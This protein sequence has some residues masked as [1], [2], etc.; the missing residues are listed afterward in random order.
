[1][2]AP[3]CMHPKEA[4]GGPSAAAAVGRHSDLA[5][6]T[7]QSFALD[8]KQ[9]STSGFDEDTHLAAAAVGHEL[10]LS[11]GRSEELEL[12]TRAFQASQ[13]SQPALVVHPRSTTQILTSSLIYRSYSY[14]VT[15]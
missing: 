5:T 6:L 1:M 14:H 12:T 13:R 10:P 11:G 15:A 9:R 4:S 2:E 7:S 3:A 8:P